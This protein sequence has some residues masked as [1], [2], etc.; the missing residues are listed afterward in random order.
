M[1]NRPRFRDR[2]IHQLDAV[3]QGDIAGQLSLQRG[4]SHLGCRRLLS[5]GIVEFARKLSPLFVL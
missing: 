4:E 2:I 5:N 1:R 3:L